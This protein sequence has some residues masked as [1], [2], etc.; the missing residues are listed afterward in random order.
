MLSTQNGEV[1][2]KPS[3]IP[4]FFAVSKQEQYKQRIQALCDHIKQI[5]IFVARDTTIPCKA[6][7]KWEEKTESMML[8]PHSNEDLSAIEKDV[9]TFR[10]QHADKLVRLA[11]IDLN[12]MLGF[13]PEGYKNE[14]EKITKTLLHAT[15]DSQT[16]IFCRRDQVNS[17]NFYIFTV[18]KDEF[19]PQVKQTLPYIGDVIKQFK[20][21]V[22]DDKATLLLPMLQCRKFMADYIDL[23]F[24]TH[25]TGVD[26]EKAHMVLVELNLE[27]KSI[28][29][30]DA[31][32]RWKLYPDTLSKIAEE[33][34]FSY[35][36]ATHYHSY[37]VQS[38]HVLCGYYTN[39]FCESIVKHGDSKECKNIKLVESDYFTKLDFI[40][41]VWPRWDD[42]TASEPEPEWL[43][44]V[45]VLDSPT[46][47]NPLRHEASR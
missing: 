25:L 1:K 39:Q 34:K 42:N 26:V 7:T 44:G 43:K 17:R 41:M 11:P 46:N 14:K 18:S 19:D 37:S 8:T 29:V 35:V 3:T 21:V 40:R 28:E 15:K 45:E 12:A 4:I 23:S 20:K 6:L 32:V 16:K 31:S 13:L 33:L 22:K 10:N 9:L 2:N 24:V 5:K 38:D 36:P 27:R 30:H 47:I